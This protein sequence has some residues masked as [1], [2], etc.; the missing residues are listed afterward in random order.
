MKPIT[1]I[2]KPSLLK[3]SSLF[4]NFNIVICDPDVS[5]AALVKN[6]LATLGCNRIYIVR[7]G[8]AVLDLM[9]EDKIDFII[10]D[11]HTKNISGIELAMHLR[12]SL[13][14]ANRMIPIV[15]LTAFNER[16]YIQTARDA[17]INEYLIKP[18][19][20]QTLLERIYNIVIEP[21]GFIL[22]KK[23]T[24]PDRRRVSSLALPPDPDKNQGFFERKSPMIVPPDAL[25]QLILDD[26]PRMIMPDY[27]LKKKIGFEVPA[28]LIVSP[29]ALAKSEAEI[30]K[31]QSDFLV[32]M[33][34]DIEDLQKTYTTLI[35]SP[36]NAKKMVK[37]I[38]ELSFSIKSR[39]GI[40]GY[41]RATEVA[42]QL[43]NFCR[44]YYDKNNA[45][46]LI[47]LEKHIQTLSAIFAKKIT[48]DGGEVG[49]QLIIDLARLINKYQS[50]P[51]Q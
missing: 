18:F 28:D 31:L 10:T 4:S 16:K 19:S 48:G 1:D 3:T 45:H 6:V 41:L 12:Q 35:Q 27:S 30:E 44:R 9:R 34:R 24:G 8:Q 25:K 50:R 49:K 7:D 32:T 39:A 33:T 22:S 47:I 51:E 14:S 46:H 38:E 13:D 5:V 42:H 20:A 11:W 43:N 40:F 15:M 2:D 17:G 26:T 29:L 36:D 21:R 23:Y 37:R